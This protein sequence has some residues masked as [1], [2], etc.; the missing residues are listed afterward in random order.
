MTV[1]WFDTKICVKGN[2]VKPNSKK[3]KAESKPKPKA[4]SDEEENG[5]DSEEEKVDSKKNLS[6][7]E[8][9]RL[10]AEKLMNEED[11]DLPPKKD[12]KPKSKP[13]APSEDEEDG[14]DE[15][16]ESEDEQEKVQ[17][18]PLTHKEK[19]ALEKKKKLDAEMARISQKVRYW[20]WAWFVLNSLLPTGWTRSQPAG[21][22]LHCSPGSQ[23]RR[24]SGQPGE[25]R[26]HQDRKVQHCC[27]GEGS[28]H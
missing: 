17:K 3:G 14:S 8:K 6:K 27:Q 11:E 5:D 26:G 16:S 12:K 15:A 22:K 2:A 28:L 23:D 10:M 25:R 7:K 19:K 4:I 20:S 21:R 1:D 24:R 13:K 9:A 18:K